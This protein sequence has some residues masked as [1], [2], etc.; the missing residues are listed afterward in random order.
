MNNSLLPIE[1]CEH[2]I[3]SC[4]PR[5]G[6]LLRRESYGTWRQTALVCSFWLPRSRL[7]LFYEVVLRDASEVDLLLQTL[8]EAPHLADMVIRLTVHADNKI[9]V[10][11]ARMPLPLLLKKCVALYLYSMNWRAYPPRYADTGFYP[12]SRIVELRLYVELRI[13]RAGVRF[14]W[15]LPHLRT[16]RLGWSQHV[17]VAKSRS[18][19][20]WWPSPQTG[21][22]Q[23]LRSLECMV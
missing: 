2:I 10:P 21:R 11:F 22:C 13:L 15:S 23:S 14:I 18:L 3:D 9:Y 6:Y 20:T 7:N 16:L 5:K 1:I 12:W 17:D 8:Q 19:T 4:R